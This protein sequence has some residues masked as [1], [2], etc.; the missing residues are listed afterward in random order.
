[1]DAPY[2]PDQADRA[3]EENL[4]FLSAVA[5]ESVNDAIVLLDGL[6]C[7][8]ETH[9]RRAFAIL[10]DYAIAGMPRSGETNVLA[11]PL[12]PTLSPTAIDLIVEKR[13]Q[14]VQ[15]QQIDGTARRKRKHATSHVGTFGPTRQ[16]T[17]MLM[18]EALSLLDQIEDTDAVP[19]L[20]LAIDR[21]MDGAN[22]D[23]GV[24]SIDRQDQ[25][26]PN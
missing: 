24:A 10:V 2:N 9:L 20:Q 19:H 11:S 12:K 23:I 16:R 21:A 1:M 14:E 6:H 4:I 25:R 8:A 18:M 22:R 7:E 5:A 13:L 3:D 26:P 15:A 17:I